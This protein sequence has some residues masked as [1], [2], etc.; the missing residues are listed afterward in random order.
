MPSGTVSKLT[1]ELLDGFPEPAHA[2][3]L[4]KAL[5]VFVKRLKIE[6]AAWSA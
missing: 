1:G 6:Y 4:P 2:A 3:A 5:A